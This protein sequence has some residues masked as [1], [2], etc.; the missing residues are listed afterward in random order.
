ML[1]CT[2]HVDLRITCVVMLLSRFW[3][4]L[5][6]LWLIFHVRKHLW[7]ASV[8]FP[9]ISAFLETN[10]GFQMIILGDSADSPLRS[11]TRG[12][13]GTEAEPEAF[14]ITRPA[15]CS[16]ITDI[17]N[18]TCFII[19]MNHIW[20]IIWMNH[21]GMTLFRLQF[22]PNHGGFSWILVEPGWDVLR[23]PTRSTTSWMTRQRQPPS[24]GNVWWFRHGMAWPWGPGDH[25]F[26]AEKWRYELVCS[27]GNYGK[28]LFLLGKSM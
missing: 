18:C 15:M 6:V 21:I 2:V 4:I 24:A 14:Q 19:Y 20:L 27:N 5:W 26:N 28:S 13:I 16:P 9:N 23:Q 3:H 1:L 10:A 12:S 11:T 25:R 8:F 17:Q 7:K 22:S